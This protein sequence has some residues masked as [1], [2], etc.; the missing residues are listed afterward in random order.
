MA[1]RGVF[2][3]F[4][5]DNGIRLKVDKPGTMTLIVCRHTY[6]LELPRRA[7]PRLGYRLLSQSGARQDNDCARDRGNQYAFHAFS[8][9]K[10]KT[11]SPAPAA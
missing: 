7:D 2:Q 11:L 6:H 5:K 1:L 10:T 4:T 8:I 9:F 3:P